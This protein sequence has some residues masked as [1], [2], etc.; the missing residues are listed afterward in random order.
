M[1]KLNWNCF[2]ISFLVMWHIDM[3]TY[4]YI[5]GKIF[6]QITSCSNRYDSSE[7]YYVSRKWRMWHKLK[8]FINSV[9]FILLFIPTRVYCNFSNCD[10]SSLLVKRSRNSRKWKFAFSLLGNSRIEWT[11]NLQ[12]KSELLN[13]NAQPRY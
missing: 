13:A 2:D 5:Y 8:F 10:I 11:T 6:F 7:I 12:R 1:I 4:R 9:Q 3:V